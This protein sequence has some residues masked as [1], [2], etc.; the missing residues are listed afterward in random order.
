[1]RL[2]KKGPPPKNFQPL[3][4]RMRLNSHRYSIHQHERNFQFNQDLSNLH[5]DQKL[6][7]I[8]TEIGEVGVCPWIV[9]DRAEPKRKSF[10]VRKTLK[11][12][13]SISKLYLF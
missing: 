1:M 8:I 7:T 10:R 13:V 9:P 11:L 12:D 6:R 4:R 2:Q 3:N 5:T